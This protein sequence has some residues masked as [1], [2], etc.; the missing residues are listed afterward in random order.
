VTEIKI[1]KAL[2]RNIKNMWHRALNNHWSDS[3]NR[4]IWAIC[5]SL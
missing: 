2:A 4:P 3:V 5:V 1:S